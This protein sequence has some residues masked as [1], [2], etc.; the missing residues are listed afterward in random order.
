MVPVSGGMVPVSNVTSA[1]L[2]GVDA[3]LGAV[4]PNGPG[5]QEPQLPAGN[6]EHAMHERQLQER[7]LYI[8]KQQRWLL[9]LRHCAKCQM[10]ETECQFGRSCRVGKELWQHILQCNETNCQFPRCHSSKDLLKHHQ[11]CQV[12]RGSAGR[13]AAA[14]AASAGPAGGSRGAA[15]APAPRAAPCMHAAASVRR[16]DPDPLARRLP[17]NA[18]CPICTPVKEYVKRIRGQGGS[19]SSAAAGMAQQQVRARGRR[20]R[21]ALR[22]A[23]CML[24]GRGGLQVLAQVR[25]S[26]AAC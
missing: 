5:G 23:G 2:S 4:M 24:P 19:S 15:P 11:K 12:R 6:G 8:Q 10:A 22:R 14:A 1:S 7:Q 9:F 25:A 3:A 17:Q 16:P 21:S 18:A 26:G 20:R 13:P